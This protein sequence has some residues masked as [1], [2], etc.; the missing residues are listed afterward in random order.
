[1]AVCSTLKFILDMTAMINLNQSAS[2]QW[3]VMPHHATEGALIMVSDPHG[4]I[5][6]F[7]MFEYRLRA[8][9]FDFIGV[10][11][12]GAVRADSGPHQ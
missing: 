2:N 5:G 6:K 12:A 11:C 7:P 9:R 3:V 1:M 8:G 10:A 4:P